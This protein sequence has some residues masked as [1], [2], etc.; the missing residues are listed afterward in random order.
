MEA[1]ITTLMRACLRA[2]LLVLGLVFVASVVLVASAVFALWMLR[3][4]WARLRGQPLTPWAFE[5]DPRTPWSRFQARATGP[6]APRAAANSARGATA[7]DDITDV[8]PHE[9]TP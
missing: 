8:E 2:L 5:F 9:R 7:I 3:A 6:V 4:L 1:F